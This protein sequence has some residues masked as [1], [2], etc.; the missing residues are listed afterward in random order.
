MKLC[1]VLRGFLYFVNLACG[2]HTKLHALISFIFFW[3][4]LNVKLNATITVDA[5]NGVKNACNTLLE[6][7]GSFYEHSDWEGYQKTSQCSLLK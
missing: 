6:W 5:E 1:F 4:A 2:I 7:I 3:F